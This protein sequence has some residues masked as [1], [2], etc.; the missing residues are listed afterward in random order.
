MKSL[1]NY[2]GK[3]SNIDIQD[4]ILKNNLD[5]DTY[6]EPFGGG[7]SAGLNLIEKGFKGRIVLND[8]DFEV[9]NFWVVLRDS[10][11]ELMDRINSALNRIFK[12]DETDD[13]LQVLKEY[14]LSKDNIDRA[15]AEYIS[16]QSLTTQGLR[17]K[18]NKF[19][20]TEIDFFL[21]SKSLENV[22]IRNC[23]YNEILMEYS[24]DK[25]FF[26]IDPPYYID[27]VNRYY[28]CDCEYF[29][30]R[31]LSEDIKNT[32][33]KM[34]ITYNDNMYIRSLYSD[35]EAEYIKRYYVAR[36]YYELYLNNF[37]KIREEK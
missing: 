19:K 8:L 23:D 12:Y 21:Q 6:C 25:T 32:K 14:K 34:L 28:R 1:L 2:I 26:L 9:Y 35:F 36:E 4:I 31:K 7:F 37:N 10:Y 27:N 20:A 11:E 29:H 16:Q 33:G 13:K 15:C 18:D 3:K 30:H 5:I 22:I 17:I 24:S